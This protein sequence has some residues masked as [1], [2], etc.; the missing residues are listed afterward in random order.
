MRIFTIISCIVITIGFIL[1]IIL[2]PKPIG[3]EWYWQSDSRVDSCYYCKTYYDDST[4]TTSLYCTASNDTLYIL[5]PYNGT[6]IKKFGVVVEF[7]K[8]TNDDFWD[9]YFDP[10][11]PISP[12]SPLNPLNPIHMD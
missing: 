2:S 9:W 11:N 5:Q 3:E 8:L 4:T 12:I 10:L 7:Y 6:E 1:L